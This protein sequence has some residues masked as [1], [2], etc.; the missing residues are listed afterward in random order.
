[1]DEI[2]STIAKL[3]KSELEESANAQPQDPTAPTT[4]LPDQNEKRKP[5]DIQFKGKAGEFFGILFVNQIFTMFTLGFYSPWAKIRVLQYLYGHTEVD[6][7]SFQFT[8]NPW[9]MLKMRIIA[10]VLFIVYMATDFMS[11][12]LAFA[13]SMA[14]IVAYFVLAPVLMIFVV[15]FRLRYTQWRGVNFSFHRDY[16]GSYRVYL[17]PMLA[18]FIVGACFW[19]LT[20]DV[21]ASIKQ[22]ELVSIFPDVEEDEVPDEQS[23]TDYYDDYSDDV[24]DQYESEEFVV[25]DVA[26]DEEAQTDSFSAAYMQDRLGL[27]Q[28]VLAPLSILLLIAL[29]P[30][31]DFINT[32]FFARNI[33]F[34]QA[35]CRFRAKAKDYYDFYLPWLFITACLVIALLIQFMGWLSDAKWIEALSAGLKLPLIIGAV[36][37]FP[38]TRA[39]LGANRQNTLLNH[40]QVEGD[41]RFRSAV[42]VMPFMSLIVVN[43]I[44]VMVSFGMLNAWAR[45]RTIR[46]LTS[47]V[48]LYPNGDLDTFV[49]TQ[50]DE[51]S[52]LGEEM[53]DVFDLELGF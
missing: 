40:L 6:H 30:F 18:F 11:G 19:Q 43:T 53:A 45:I 13:I 34:G 28:I 36:L 5:F 32:R 49:K 33:R 24:Y 14:F 44:A 26:S 25:N 7:S 21:S 42:P 39:Y 4:P 15:S 47:Y 48:R 9:S 17:A 20:V 29:I 52:S 12:F 8:A 3:E 51:S 16:A 2:D 1:M 10:V 46:F 23:N 38:F 27:W 37:Y 50:M 35:S 31:F 41:H 22:G